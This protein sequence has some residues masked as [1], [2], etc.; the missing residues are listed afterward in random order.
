MFNKL[1]G[2]FRSQKI[3]ED[4]A[5]GA[6]GG[7]MSQV[8]MW[9]ASPVEKTPAIQGGVIRRGPPIFN[10]PPPPEPVIYRHR[11]KETGKID[12]IGATNNGS[13]RHNE[14]IRSGKFDPSQQDLGWQR[15]RDGASPEDVYGHETKKIK[16][17]RPPLNRRNGGGGPRWKWQN[18][19]QETET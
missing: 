3:S 16:Q 9:N 5:S 4:K 8:D 10:R 13:R 1:V 17:H 12:Y 2:F 19:S 7:R 15:A 18:P 6:A 11:N 14:H